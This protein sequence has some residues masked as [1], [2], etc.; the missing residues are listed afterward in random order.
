MSWLVD[1]ERRAV[2]VYQP[3]RP[4]QMLAG[5]SAVYGEGPV[6]GFVLELARI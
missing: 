2:D 6:G 5:V 1:P 4:P 3:G